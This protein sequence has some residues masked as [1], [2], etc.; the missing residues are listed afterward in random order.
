MFAATPATATGKPRLFFSHTDFMTI[1]EE[2]VYDS[3]TLSTNYDGLKNMMR[4]VDDMSS[5][6][7]YALVVVSVS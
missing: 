1:S 4:D 2:A 7:K 5:S 3:A 6:K